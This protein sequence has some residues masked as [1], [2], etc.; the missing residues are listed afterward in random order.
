MKA[1]KIILPHF[2]NIKEERIYI[3]IFLQSLTVINSWISTVCCMPWGFF[4]HVWLF[5]TPWTVAYQAPLS[6]GFPRQEYWSRL[7]C[8]TPRNLLDSGI[9]PMSPVS[10]VDSLPLSLWSEVLNPLC[11]SQIS[12][13]KETSLIPK[14]LVWSGDPQIR[15][16][17]SLVIVIIFVHGS[18]MIQV[19]LQ[20][21]LKLSTFK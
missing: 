10:P 20:S 19:L 21:H 3:F 1:N 9:K 4:S 8:S 14:N 5:V 11:W 15:S 2:S 18:F 13:Q 12:C 6:M 7:P 17:E 16:L